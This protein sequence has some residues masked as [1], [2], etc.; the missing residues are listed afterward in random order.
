M[1]D[2][3]DKMK[4][5]IKAKPYRLGIKRYDDLT[6]FITSSEEHWQYTSL[7]LGDVLPNHCTWA[8]QPAMLNW[9]AYRP[10]AI[11]VGGTKYLVTSRGEMAQVFE[12]YNGDR[13]GEN[14]VWTIPPY[15]YSAS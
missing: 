2:A 7:L 12:L 3:N 6:Y 14:C 8:I 10:H 15:R 11:T 4:T 9:K 1:L 13:V 5:Q